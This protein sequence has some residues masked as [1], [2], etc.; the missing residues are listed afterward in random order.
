MNFLT[1]IRAISLTI[2]IY[3]LQ[4]IKERNGLNRST[5][6]IIYGMKAQS[7]VWEV[8]VVAPQSAGLDG[9]QIQKGFM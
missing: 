6:L 4:T 7:A 1:W 8:E 3:L 5:P 9:G 2:I